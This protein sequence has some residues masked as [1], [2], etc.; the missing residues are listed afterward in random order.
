VHFKIQT[1]HETIQHVVFI[2]SIVPIQDEIIQQQFFIE[3]KQV[4][5]YTMSASSTAYVH[6]QFNMKQ[7]YSL[8]PTESVG[9]LIEMK[10]YKTP[11]WI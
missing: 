8:R 11:I 9:R 4:S 6:N 3:L 5:I 2:H 1:Q 10:F 7:N